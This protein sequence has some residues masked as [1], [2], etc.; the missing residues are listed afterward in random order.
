MTERATDRQAF[1][2]VSPRI[3]VAECEKNAAMRGAQHLFGMTRFAGQK[4][5][6][7]ARIPSQKEAVGADSG[8]PAASPSAGPNEGRY[9]PKFNSKS[10]RTP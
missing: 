3:P 9:R 2:I 10:L 4:Q 1:P 8:L 6:V 5:P 7:I